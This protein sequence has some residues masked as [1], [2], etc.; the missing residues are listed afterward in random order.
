MGAPS[1]S[2][3]GLGVAS[4]FYPVL[5]RARVA[6]SFPARGG[7]SCQWVVFVLCQYTDR[8]NIRQLKPDTNN[9]RINIR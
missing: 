6:S 9:K 7:N 8:V 5:R 1:S 4:C 2:V 3:V